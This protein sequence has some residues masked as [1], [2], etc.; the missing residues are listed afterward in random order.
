MLLHAA[1]LLPVYSL[2]IAYITTDSAQGQW[3]HNL[4][5]DGHL[6]PSYSLLS[7]SSWLIVLCACQPADC[8]NTTWL[9]A[10]FMNSV[11][12]KQQQQIGI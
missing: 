8:K 1:M 3:C 12:G 7:D 2:I 5:A 4:L 11:R 10:Q 9:Q 6:K